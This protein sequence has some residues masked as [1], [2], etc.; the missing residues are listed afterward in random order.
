[1][2]ALWATHLPD[3]T[4]RAE[5]PLPHAFAGGGKPEHIHSGQMGQQGMLQSLCGRQE[6]LLSTVHQPE[7]AVRTGGLQYTS[8]AI[9]TRTGSRSITCAPCVLVY[10]SVVIRSLSRSTHMSTS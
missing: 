4:W 2:S 7:L 8:K 10:G 9:A 5:K 3:M 1:M 6:E